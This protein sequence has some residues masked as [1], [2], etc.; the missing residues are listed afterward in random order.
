ML[1]RRPWY[2]L[3]CSQMTS[4]LTH[5]LELIVHRP[6]VQLVI[7]STRC[8]LLFIEW[9][10]ETTYFLFMALKASEKVIL[11]SKVSLQDCLIF[12]PRAQYAVAP[13]YSTHTSFMTLEHPEHFPFI[14]VPDLHYATVRP[15]WQMLPSLGPANRSHWISRAKVMQLCHLTITRWPDIDA[16][17]ETY[18]KVIVWRPID[19]VQIEVVLKGRC[20][21]D[22]VG[23]FRNLPRSFTRHNYLIFIQ[24]CQW[25]V[26]GHA[27]RFIK[28]A[29]ATS[30][31]AHGHRVV[32]LGL[33]ILGRGKTW[34]CHETTTEIHKTYLW[35]PGTL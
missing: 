35:C 6:N 2:G 23:D 7:V 19:K 18:C 25:V 27:G 9:P 29:D 1:V 28:V 11:F 17:R 34:S 33:C 21:Q 12:W 4:K 31:R 3:D 32:V 8:Q 24:A 20:V 30:R 26:M 15:D 14:N 16:V 10:L 5:R 22:F 13:R